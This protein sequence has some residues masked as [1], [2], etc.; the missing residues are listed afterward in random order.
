MGQAPGEFGQTAEVATSFKKDFI[1]KLPVARTFQ[2]AALMTPGRR[3]QRSESGAMSISG[4]AS[5]ENLFMVNGVV[6][7]DNLRSTPLNL[8]IEDALQETTT[9]TSGVS[10]EYG[11]FSGGVVNAITKSGGNEPQRV[12]PRDARQRQLDRPHPLP[13]RPAHGQDHPHLRGDARRADPQGP[14][15]VLRGA[16]R[17]RELTETRNTSYTNHRT[18]TASSTRSATRAS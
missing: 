18:S 12:V 10:A 2:Q 17:M 16:A 14:A 9:T 3:E 8:F 7:Q 15:L 6:V 11:R 5:F 1:E 4:A 13:Q